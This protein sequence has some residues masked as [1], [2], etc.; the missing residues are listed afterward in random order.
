[1]DIFDLKLNYKFL[2]RKH[3]SKQNFGQKL[4]NIFVLF[5]LMLIGIKKIK[6]K[7]QKN[8]FFFS[9]IFYKLF[10]SLDIF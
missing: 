6:R 2:N 8:I 9:L 1:M 5:H 10:K 3:K 7:K 4:N